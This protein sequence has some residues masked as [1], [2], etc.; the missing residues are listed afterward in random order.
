MGGVS[1]RHKNT[2]SLFKNF[3]ALH[4]GKHSS[5]A[6][7]LNEMINEAGGKEWASV[8]MKQDSSPASPVG[9]V[10]TWEPSLGK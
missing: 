7:G 3:V 10:P 6:P 1:H 8:K 4:M 2:W 9:G 5:L